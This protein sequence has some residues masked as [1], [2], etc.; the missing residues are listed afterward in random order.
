MSNQPIVNDPEPTT[1]EAALGALVPARF[2]INRDLVMF[3]AG[4]ASARRSSRRSRPWIALAASLALIAL[5]EA[6]LL[7]R[8]P[9]PQV[10]DRVIVVREPAPV[11]LEPADEPIVVAH[12]PTPR[13]DVRPL[14]LGRTNHQRL[15]ALVIRYGLD[16]LPASPKGVWTESR[17]WPATSGRMLQ[18]ELCK[19]LEPGDPS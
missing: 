6:A 7:A 1:I 19:L 9:S 15:A 2:P 14:S 5:G 8:R 18:A 11:P 16:G 13:P 10:V 4:Q 17:T 3:Q 12:S